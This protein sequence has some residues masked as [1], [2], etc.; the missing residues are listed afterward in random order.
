MQQSRRMAAV[1]A[2]ANA[3]AGYAVSVVV[4]LAV[5]PLWGILVDLV[6]NLSIGAVF[7]A[8]SVVRSYLLRRAFD[9]MLAGRR[10]R[11]RGAGP[12]GTE[13]KSTWRTS[14]KAAAPGKAT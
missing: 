11:D 10:R 2:L 7:F 5:F 4:Q 1:E 12:T 6:D 9:M 13:K 8:A 3:V 14:V